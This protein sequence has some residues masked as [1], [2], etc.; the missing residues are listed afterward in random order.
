MGGLFLRTRD[1][2][3][4]IE[5][6]RQTTSREHPSRREFGSS[7]DGGYHLLIRWICRRGIALESHQTEMNSSSRA[8]WYCARI[9]PLARGRRLVEAIST[10][11]LARA[12]WSISFRE[13]IERKR[14]ISPFAPN[15]QKHASPTVYSGACDVQVYIVRRLIWQVLVLTVLVTSLSSPPPIFTNRQR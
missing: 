8:P 4:R 9:S 15:K 12:R 2:N 14:A 6:G 3:R 7:R 11:I 5:V 1:I 13:T 10:H